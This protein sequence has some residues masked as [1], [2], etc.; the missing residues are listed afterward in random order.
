MAIEY[1]IYCIYNGG[2]PFILNT[3]DNLQI[4]K[5]RLYD[6]ISLEKERNRPYYVYNDFYTNE[7]PS[8]IHG[9][10]FCIKQREVSEWTVYSENEQNNISENIIYLKNFIK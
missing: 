8:T 2:K 9:K 7:Y 5:I 4:A 10:F 3:Y 1:T 6:M